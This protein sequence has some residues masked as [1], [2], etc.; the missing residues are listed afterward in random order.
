MAQRCLRFAPPDFSKP[1]GCEEVVTN[2]SVPVIQGKYSNGEK[3]VRMGQVR[4]QKG[5]FGKKRPKSR[6]G[7]VE[8]KPTSNH[9]RRWMASSRSSFKNPKTSIHKKVLIARMMKQNW[10]K[11]VAAEQEVTFP[12][13]QAQPETQTYEGPGF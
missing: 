11:F 8:Q 2:G 13:T 6:R 5:V 10:D 12:V 9:L 7:P 4:S 3:Y 1:S